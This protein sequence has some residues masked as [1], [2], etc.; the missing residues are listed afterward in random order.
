MLNTRTPLVLRYFIWSMLIFAFSMGVW[1]FRALR[2]LELKTVSTSLPF[3]QGPLW[4][5]YEEIEIPFLSIPLYGQLSE[6]R[7]LET[8]RDIVHH[9]KKAGAKVVIVPLPEYFPPTSTSQK[10]ID[11]MLKDSIAVLGVPDPLTTSYSPFLGQPYDRR[12]RWWVQH[13]LHNQRKVPWGV[14]SAYNEFVSPLVRFVPTGFRETKSGAPVSDVSVVAL[15]QYF[16]IPDNA[17]IQPYASRLQ[18]GPLAIPIAKNGI[19]YLRQSF[20]LKNQSFLVAA[21]DQLSDSLRYFADWSSGK[22]STEPLEK[23][24][25]KHQGKIVM[26]NGY[27]I[28]RG[29]FLSNTNLYV[30][31]FGSVFQRS[32]LTVHNEWNVLL[33]TTL[34]VFLSV[35]SYTVRNGLTVLLSFALFVAMTVLSVWLLDSH[36]VIFDPVYVFVPIVLCGILLPIVKTS[37]EKKIAEATIKSLEEENRRLLE[38]QRRFTRDQH[39]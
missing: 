5:H 20:R 9:L 13:P 22:P 31:V 24:W 12:A 10:A 39:F 37:G 8:A 1:G 2:S 3:R 33:I 23:I 15:R 17:D 35:F 4:K 38:L 11:E 18:I 27:G 25:A 36:N 19:S 28:R 14:L 26:L 34:V 6:E 30:Q 7:Y 16:D 21:T 29:P 32:F